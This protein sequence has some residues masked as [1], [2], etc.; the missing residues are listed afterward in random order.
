MEGLSK[1]LQDLISENSVWR[2]D[3]SETTIPRVP[4]RK[5]CIWTLFTDQ[6]T[7]VNAISK[8]YLQG[9]LTC[10]IQEI[11]AH[12]GIDQLSLASVSRMAKDLN[13]Q[14]HAF[15]QRP[16]EQEIPYLFVDAS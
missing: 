1:W 2:N 11:V 15:L 4:F 14:V 6:E 5:T 12:L 9:V 7:L 13:K 10:R 8:S 16:I 3:P